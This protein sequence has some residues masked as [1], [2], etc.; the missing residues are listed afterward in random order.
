MMPSKRIEDAIRSARST[1]SAATDERIMAVAEAAMARPNEQ[2]AAPVRTSGS[3]RRS[4]MRS[5]WTR[6]AT[7]AAIIAAIMLAMHAWT[8]SVDGTSITLAQVRQAMQEIDW[9]QLT[10]TSKYNEYGETVWYSFASEVEIVDA[11]I[12]IGYHDF[13]V[14]KNLFWPRGGEHVYES[15]IET[16]EFAHGTG[17]PFEMIDK[18]LRLAQAEDGKEVVKGRGTYQ[19]QRVEI[20]TARHVKHGSER[21]IIVYIDVD[22]KLPIAA[23]YEREGTYRVDPEQVYIE[24]KYPETGPADIYE[25]GAPTSAQI[26]PAPDP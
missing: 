20:W 25:A 22:R 4:I 8:G 18:T 16:K 9:M 17:G 2:H 19:G 11:N 5:N 10:K 14:R 6:L 12:G 26:K 24:F 3:M 7:A 21:T 1:T 15:P 13:K 23:T